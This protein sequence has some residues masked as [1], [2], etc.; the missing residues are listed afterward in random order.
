MVAPWFKRGLSS[1]TRLLLTRIFIISIGL[2]ILVWGLWYPLGQDLWDYMAISGAIYS[3]G[4]FALLAFG[5]Y[6]RRASRVGAYLSLLSAF[7]VLLG[8]TPVQNMFSAPL[9][10]IK[11]IFNVPPEE[12]IS[13]AVIGLAVLVMAIILMVVGSLL[14]PDKRPNSY[15]AE[16]GEA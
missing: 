5:L 14:F 6:W 4:G 12:T 7:F 1:K 13:S 15:H 10:P 9:A 11:R 16:R 8:L 3:I 2:F